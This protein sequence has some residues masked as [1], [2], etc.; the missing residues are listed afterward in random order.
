MQV[1]TFFYACIDVYMCIQKR[2]VEWCDSYD[3]GLDDLSFSPR[4]MCL[5]LCITVARTFQM[6]TAKEVEI[7][8]E[9]K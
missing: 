1:Y 8:M 7:A 5:C 4:V 6:V 9:S 3:V 2:G